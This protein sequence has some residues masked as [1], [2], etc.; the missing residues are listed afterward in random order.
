VIAQSCWE[1]PGVGVTTRIEIA[2]ENGGTFS[3]K[4][5]PTPWSESD[6]WASGPMAWAELVQALSARGQHSTDITDAF[7]AAGV[8]WPP[9][10]AAR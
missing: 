10:D 6:Y 4:I 1:D 2:R 7:D 3:A 8:E 9:G 5:I